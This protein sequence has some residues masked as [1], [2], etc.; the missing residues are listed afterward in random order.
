M[1]KINLGFCESISEANKWRLDRCFFP[2]KVGGYPVW[3]DP[4]IGVGFDPKC[5]VC[6][7]NLKFL[8]QMYGPGNSEKAF[9]RTI[10][11]FVCSSQ[12]FCPAPPVVIRQQLERQNSFYPP[13]APDYEVK[14]KI[15][16]PVMQKRKFF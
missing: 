12:N 3:L 8:L 16:C 6:K 5:S 15:Y 13:E 2:S 9:H 7:C 11:V 4:K 1:S 10:F 14:Q